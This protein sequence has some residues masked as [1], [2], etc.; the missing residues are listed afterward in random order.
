MA[1]P[2][3]LD[4]DQ[5]HLTVGPGESARLALTL[6]NTSD[7]V[8]HL[9]VE[10]RGLPPGARAQTEPP[11]VK[12]LPGAVAECALTLELPTAP[13][14]D[15]GSH[16]LGVLARSPHRREV[17]RCEEVRLDVPAL[18][19]LAM[20]V[21]PQL[22][23]AG[24]RA[25]FTATLV[26]EGNTALRISLQGSDPERRVQFRFTPPDVALRPRQTAHVAVTAVADRPWTG[27][28]AR[29][30]LTLTAG[31]GDVTAAQTVTL[32]QPPRLAPVV[33]RSV[34]GVVALLVMAGALLLSRYTGGGD[35][36][37][38]RNAGA[39]EVVSSGAGASTGPSASVPPAE[40][41]TPTEPAETST[42]TEEPAETASPTT[43]TSDLPTATPPEPSLVRLYDGQPGPEPRFAEGDTWVT[44]GFEVTAAPTVG[45]V[46]GCAGAGQLAVHGTEDSAFTTAAGAVPG[47]C[48]GVAL[49]VSFTDDVVPATE[50]VLEVEEEGVY[51]VSGVDD[52]G[53]PIP[54]VD[55]ASASN[56]ITTL[57]ARPIQSITIAASGEGSRP[58]LVGIRRVSFTP[59]P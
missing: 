47:E 12:L 14:A 11:T 1:R 57:A 51:E 6:R 5:E 9:Q 15:A 30:A 3:R 48:N 43:S 7:V 34:A 59:A 13:P 54:A 44:E 20:S 18:P 45:P 37:E 58:A 16:V 29:R 40:T 49:T 36:G 2:I 53:R 33:L 19:G 28:E 8:E 41:A 22:V 17:S 56:M 24:G 23:R 52:Q 35:E 50:V 26:N 32:V 21:E 10:V 38:S 25:G 39:T 31:A 4:L 42:T 46:D 55:G 27:Q